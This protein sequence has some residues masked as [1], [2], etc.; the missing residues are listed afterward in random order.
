MVG[1]N[2]ESGQPT[3]RAHF[4]GPGGITF[5]APTKCFQGTDCDPYPFT[6]IVESSMGILGKYILETFVKTG[7][8]D[9][10]SN[11]IV[12]PGHTDI[13]CFFVLGFMANGHGPTCLHSQFLQSASLRSNSPVKA[14]AD[15]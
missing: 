13:H 14:S 9:D 1:K 15:A 7:K 10:V 6:F 11:E 12:C 5:L 3:T 2:A 4:F 8:V